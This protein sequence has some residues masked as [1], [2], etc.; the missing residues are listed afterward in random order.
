MAGPAASAHWHGGPLSRTDRRSSLWQVPARDVAL[1]CLSLL[2]GLLIAVTVAPARARTGD[3]GGPW[4]GRTITYHDQSNWPHTVREAT[5]RWNAAQIGVRFVPVAQR[6]GAQLLIVSD[7]QAHIARACPRERASD[8]CSAYSTI[9][10]RANGARVV[11][12]TA[13]AAQDRDPAAV[14]ARMVVHELGHVLGLGHAHGC[15]V[16]DHDLQMPGC[17]MEAV[18]HVGGT[19]VFP[20]V[21]G[22]LPDDIARAARLY[23]VRTP[24]RPDPYCPLP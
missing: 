20:E 2:A 4:P 10:Y 6:A 22:P 24:R 15:A 11:L 18:R 19:Y 17:H 8:W 7:T 21:C 9:G 16:M 5:Q 13:T 14:E 3:E 23:G 1:L 12:P